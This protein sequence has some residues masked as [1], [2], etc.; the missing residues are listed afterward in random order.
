[1]LFQKIYCTFARELRKHM[2]GIRKITA[3]LTA[4]FLSAMPGLGQTPV[5]EE[6]PATLKELGFEDIRTE[7]RYDTLYASIE[8]RAYRGTFRGAAAAIQMK[9]PT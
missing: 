7:L 3:I 5:T 8:D 9:G 4:L 6:I 2:N 1:M